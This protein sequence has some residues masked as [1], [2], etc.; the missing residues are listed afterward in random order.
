MCVCIPSW[1]FWC[2]YCLGS[3]WKPQEKMQKEILSVMND[4]RH[5]LLVYSSTLE[6][7]SDSTNFY[8]IFIYLFFWI[9]NVPRNLTWNKWKQDAGRSYWRRRPRFNSWWLRRRQPERPSSVFT[10]SVRQPTETMTSPFSSLSDH[11]RRLLLPNQ[12]DLLP[13][14]AVPLNDHPSS[15]WT[16]S[17]ESSPSLPTFNSRTASR[18]IKVMHLTYL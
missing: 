5:Q 11:R 16:R 18:A 12:Q 4:T 6:C 8:F 3:L 14:A 1:G 7:R 15:F 13:V 10:L 9:W 2:I 17:R